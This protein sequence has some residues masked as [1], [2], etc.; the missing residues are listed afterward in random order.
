MLK[1]HWRT[2]ECQISGSRVTRIA[3]FLRLLPS[4]SGEI[5]KLYRGDSSGI[6]EKP[7]C[8]L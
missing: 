7:K 3:N 5:R 8:H 6:L 4:K 1:Q 2:K